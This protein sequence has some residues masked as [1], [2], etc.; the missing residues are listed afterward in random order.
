MDTASY[1]DTP[2]VERRLATLYHQDGMT[3][4]PYWHISLR[5]AGSINAS[6]REMAHYV[7][8]YLKR[9]AYGGVQLLPPEAIDRMEIPTSTYAAREGLR[10]GYGLGNYATVRDR[11]VF[12]GHNG[13]VFGGLTELAYLPEAGVGYV[14]MINSSNAGALNEI[15]ALLRNFVT[16]TLPKPALPAAAPPSAL[17]P[18]YAGW[19][20]PASPR[21]ERTRFLARILGLTLVRADQG[22][23]SLHGLLSRQR[24][25][26]AVSDRLF[27]REAETVPTLALIADATDGTLLQVSGETLRRVPPWLPWL[28]FGVMAAALLLAASSLAFALVWVPRKIFGDLRSVGHLRVRALPALAALALLLCSIPLLAPGGGNPIERLGTPTLWSVGLFIGTLAFAALAVLGLV[29]SL[30][31]RHRGINRLVW[32]HAFAASLLLT[33]VAAYLASWGVIGI[34]LWS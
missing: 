3:P 8:F 4:F 33:V 12:H 19:Y 2:E 20:E 18:G 21:N 7:E 31:C 10:S 17:A 22:I 29:V 23:L 6:A 28:E 16:R 9:G 27:R 14:L 30:L 15:S 11:W 5:P 25:F 34:R 13:G 26:V 1:F 32:W 24:D